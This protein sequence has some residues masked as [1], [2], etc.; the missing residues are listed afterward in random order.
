MVYLQ[1]CSENLRQLRVNFFSAKRT[2]RLSFALIHV[3]A[4]SRV[5]FL[6]ALT[7]QSISV[8]AINPEPDLAFLFFPCVHFSAPLRPKGSPEGFPQ[9]DTGVAITGLTPITPTCYAR[10]VLAVQGLAGGR[11]QYAA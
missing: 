6:P 5:V 4:A 10:R 7:G 9:G 3:R 2:T 1:L 11:I 8:T